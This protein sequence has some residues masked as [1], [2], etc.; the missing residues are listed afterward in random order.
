MQSKFRTREK[1]VDFSF[2]NSYNDSAC[3]ASVAQSVVHLTRNEKVACSSH[4]TS[5][6]E[7]SRICQRTNAAFLHNTRKGEMEDGL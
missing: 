1:A 5:S 6:T 7:K 4:V 3:D 2:E